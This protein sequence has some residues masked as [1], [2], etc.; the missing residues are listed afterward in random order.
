MNDRK[1]PTA[2]TAAR[3]SR[4]WFL[5]PRTWVIAAV[6]A[7][8]FWFVTPSSYSAGGIRF[9]VHH[10]GSPGAVTFVV[11]DSTGQPLSGVTVMSESFSGTTQ[12]FVTD[13]SGIA[14]IR[15]GES[16]VLAVY[17]QGH[18][19]RFRPQYSF[20][21]HFAP[22]CSRGLTLNVSIRNDRNA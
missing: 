12:E 14:T 9:T 3:T 19:F 20:L 11:R 1:T 8:V 18:E 15:P 4:R 21:E 10:S 22:D 7:F 16:E 5:R 17:I 13:A 6:L 2:E